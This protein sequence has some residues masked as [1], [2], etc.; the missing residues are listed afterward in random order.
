M[1]TD[2][3]RQVAHWYRALTAHDVTIRLDEVR[4]VTDHILDEEA[5]RHIP[6]VHAVR[7]AAQIPGPWFTWSPRL[8]TGWPPS[9][10]K[11]SR[12]SSSGPKENPGPHPG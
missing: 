5:D 11:R 7:L 1:Q 4:R 10:P 2:R 6:P 3:S 8:G 9:I 12:P